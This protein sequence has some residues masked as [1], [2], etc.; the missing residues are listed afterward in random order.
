MD[1]IL[2]GIFSGIVLAFLIGP[3]FFTILQTS[4]E[5]GFWS[6]FSV[7]VGVSLSDAIYIF[8]C[9]LGVYQVFDKG[10]FRE[11]LAYF[12]GIVLLLFGLYYLLIKSRKLSKYD[13]ERIKTQKPVRL[14]LKGF[15]INGLSPMVLI[16]WLGTVGVATTK[17]GYATPGKAI[18]YFAAIVGTVFITDIL[19]AKLADK[20]R[21]ALTPK[22]IK[23]LNIVVGIVMVIFGGRLIAM[24]DNFSTF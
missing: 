17:F 12:G 15:I 19:K 9:Y 18:P 8:L 23:T 13:P 11:Y 2:N 4:V 5:R 3:V 7:A 14:F 16:F 20:L 24:A 22:F 1:I 6:G 21:S 10:N